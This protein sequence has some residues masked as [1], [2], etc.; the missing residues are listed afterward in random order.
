MT[1]LFFTKI[2]VTFFPNSYDIL[3][4]NSWAILR[5][6]SFIIH[7][8]KRKIFFLQKYGKCYVYFFLI[9]LY[10]NWTHGPQGGEDL[11]DA[12]SCRSFFAEEP[13]MIGLLCGKWHL[14]MK[15][16]I[17]LR[18]PVYCDVTHLF[19]AKINLSFFLNLMGPFCDVAHLHAWHDA[20]T[21]LTQNGP[22]SFNFVT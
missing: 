17:T 13:L 8:N 21:W 16:P 3:W 7:K 15:H 2:N 14:K 22:M 20:F 19:F 4:L 10:C 11:Q 12:L 9:W 5:S 1:H 18:H 6:N